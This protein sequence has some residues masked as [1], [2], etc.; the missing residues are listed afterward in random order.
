MNYLI[1]FLIAIAVIIFVVKVKKFDSL[2]YRAIYAVVAF[3]LIVSVVIL[4][5]PAEYIKYNSSEPSQTKKATNKKEVSQIQF[6]ALKMKAEGFTQEQIVESFFHE[7][8]GKLSVA[9]EL[10]KANFSLPVIQKFFKNYKI[11]EVLQNRKL[12]K[13]E[14]SRYLIEQDIKRFANFSKMDRVEIREME[15]KKLSIKKIKNIYPNYEANDEIKAI[16][17]GN[18]GK[19][20]REIKKVFPNYEPKK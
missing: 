20:L 9:Q 15:R 11:S 6:L 12:T 10:E 14:Y 4:V 7:Y 2:L 18:S 5:Q 3:V 13:A 16:D 1:L 8:P 17:F 19:S